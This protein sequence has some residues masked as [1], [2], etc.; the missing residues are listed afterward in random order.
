MCKL[1]EDAWEEK[2]EE[3]R[4]LEEALDDLRAVMP[5]FGEYIRLKIAYAHE[6]RGML[7]GAR[8]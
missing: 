8:R 6:A 1:M 3:A 7:W 4:R 2:K 5:E